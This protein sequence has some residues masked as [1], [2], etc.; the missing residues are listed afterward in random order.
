MR[1]E[2]RTVCRRRVSHFVCRSLSAGVVAIA[3]M[4]STLL[5]INAILNTENS[6]FMETYMIIELLTVQSILRQM[7]S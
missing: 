3:T 7:K 2:P 5:H 6:G 4:M 1:L